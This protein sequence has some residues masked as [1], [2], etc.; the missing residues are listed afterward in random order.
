MYSAKKNEKDG[1]MNLF[2]IP[3]ALFDSSSWKNNTL[4]QK[5]DIYFY[6]Y[7]LTPLMVFVSY[8]LFYLFFKEK[9]NLMLG[10][11]SKIGKLFK[12]YS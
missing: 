1:Q 5:L 9:S 7:G 3:E 2:D 4:A 10:V 11:L 8:L 12:I 6:D